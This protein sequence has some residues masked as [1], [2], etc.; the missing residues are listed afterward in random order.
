MR[1]MRLM[2]VSTVVL[3]TAW[4]CGSS[5]GNVQPNTPPVAKFTAPSCTVSVPCPFTDA[6]TDADGSIASQTWDF[7]DGSAPATGPTPSHTFTTAN[8]YQVKLT[9]TD[10]G[11]D[12]NSTT[13]PV[14]VTASANVPPVASFTAPACNAGSDC[15]FHST[16]TD[17]DGNISATHWDFG[18]GASADGVDVVHN[19][20]AAGSFNVTLTVTD[21]KGAASTPVVQAVT[22]SPAAAQDCTASGSTEVICTI[23]LAQRSTVSI[24]LTSV[25]C[26]IGGN[27][28]FIPPPKPR[29]Q[30]IFTN[31]CSQVPPQE[32]TLRDDT[33]ATLV[34]DAGTQLPIQFHQGTLAPTDPPHDPPA[35]HIASPSANNWTINIDDGGNKGGPGEPD[36][37][38]AILTVVATPQ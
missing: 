19:Y 37:T 16:S 27:R 3:A 11:G 38:D 36:F 2:A 6:S 22:V 1:S 9:V 18:D 7:G 34:F 17:A 35:G 24:T 31:V 23:T 26:E 25:S 10:N 32:Y 15:P 20:S 29:A 21:D 30:T 4:A 8:T 13:V 5:G 33:G 14:I 28:L 12:A